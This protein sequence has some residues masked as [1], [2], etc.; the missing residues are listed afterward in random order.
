MRLL[1]IQVLMSDS[2]GIL[3]RPRIFLAF[4]LVVTEVILGIW[5]YKIPENEIP[6]ER[7]LLCL[8]L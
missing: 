3:Y 8:Q 5:L 6:D 1:S 7:I 4:T 2:N